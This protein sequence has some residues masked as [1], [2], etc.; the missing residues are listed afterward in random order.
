MTLANGNQ[1]FSQSRLRRARSIGAMYRPVD[2]FA[3]PGLSSFFDDPRRDHYE[4]QESLERIAISARLTHQYLTDAVCRDRWRE[5]CKFAW[6]IAALASFFH[7]FFLSFASR[8]HAAGI[9]LR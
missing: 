1:T 4:L 9:Q 5:E 3:V 8:P 7:F 2:I 6:L